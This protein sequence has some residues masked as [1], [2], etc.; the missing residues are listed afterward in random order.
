M[1]GIATSPT[2]AKSQAAGGTRSRVTD[3]PAVR[4][5]GISRRIE[6]SRG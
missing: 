1:T 5:A 6:L 4:A 3:A 2:N